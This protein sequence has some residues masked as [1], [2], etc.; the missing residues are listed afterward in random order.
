MQPTVKKG[1]TKNIKN[2]KKVFHEN[3]ALDSINGIFYYL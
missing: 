3:Y 2:A 1:A